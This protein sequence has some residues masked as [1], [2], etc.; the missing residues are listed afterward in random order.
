MQVRLN[1]GRSQFGVMCRQCTAFAMKE[2][3]REAG[4]SLNHSSQG[5]WG[6]RV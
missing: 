4:G 3:Q 6:P 2:L 5:D 1:L